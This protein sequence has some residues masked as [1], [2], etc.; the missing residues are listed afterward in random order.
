MSTTPA[1]V[2]TWRGVM[3]VSHCSFVESPHPNQES[4]CSA[5]AVLK[6]ALCAAI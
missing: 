5:T 4:M 2:F 6:I 1:S 3:N